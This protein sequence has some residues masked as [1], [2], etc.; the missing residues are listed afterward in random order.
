MESYFNNTIFKNH[1]GLNQTVENINNLQ[2]ESNRDV[3]TNTD[4]NNNYDL[5]S[6]SSKKDLVLMD[7]TLNVT[8]EVMSMD[9]YRS[10]QL[11]D[12]FE[13]MNLGNLIPL[14]C[15]HN[16]MYTHAETDMCSLYYLNSKFIS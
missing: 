15:G 11:S 5:D 7:T 10:A 12:V 13:E 2:G 6:P 9:S 1:R 16:G 3:L 8:S 14:S 4:T